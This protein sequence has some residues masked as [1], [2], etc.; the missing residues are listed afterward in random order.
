MSLESSIG[1]LVKSSETLT[2]TVRQTVRDIDSRIEGRLKSMSDTVTGFVDTWGINGNSTL[3]VGPN[4]KFTSIQSAWDSLNGKALKSDVLIKVDDGVYEMGGLNL[5]NQPYAYRIRIQGNISKPENCILKFIPDSNRFSHGVIFR[6]TYWLD[7]SGFKLVGAFSD[8]NVT[9]RLIQLSGGTT[10]INSQTNSIILEGGRVGA[11]IV[12]GATWVSTGV[13]IVDAQADA[14]YMRASIAHLGRISVKGRG[15]TTVT[16]AP[17]HAAHLGNRVSRGVVAADNSSL[18]ASYA[19]IS[20][21]DYAMLSHAGSFLVSNCAK[22]SKV[23]IGQAAHY[24]AVLWANTAKKSD[25]TVDVVHVTD[26]MQ[27]GFRAVDG[28]M[29]FAFAAIA[30]RCKIGYYCA[31]PGSQI[32]AGDNQAI[33]CE[34]GFLAEHGAAIRAWNTKSKAKNCTTLYTPPE[35]GIAAAN[36]SLI[37]YS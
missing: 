24:G 8:T 5:V 11:E 36:A 34:K 33:D 19:T 22:I 27:Q 21:V 25:G 13:R 37:L 7:F 29:V 28:G 4:R 32:M 23:Q 2:D 31:N 6:N 9:H 14:V 20:D 15:A 17:A 16:N 1:D 10:R 18:W 3:E 12:D 35:S 30:E 26:A